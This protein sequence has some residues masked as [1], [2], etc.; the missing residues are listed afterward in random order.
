MCAENEQQELCQHTDE[1]RAFVG[2]YAAPELRSALRRGYTLKRVFESWTFG[3]N[4]STLLRN[5]IH[6]FMLVK[7]KASKLP[8]DQDERVKHISTINTTYNTDLT[9]ADFQYNGSLR[10]IAKCALN[11]M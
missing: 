7:L 3:R 5:M 6:D 1:E 8:A 10:L 9:E 11:S 2:T 4:D